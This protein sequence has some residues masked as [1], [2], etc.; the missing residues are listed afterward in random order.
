MTTQDFENAARTVSTVEIRSTRL[1]F[2][3][4]GFGVAAWAPL[5]PFVA[6]RAGLDAA[7]LG[8]LLLCL[9]IGSLAA[10]PVA[11]ALAGRWGAR[12]V[13]AA[14]VAAVCAALAALSASGSIPVLALAL[15]GLGAG[16][17]GLD[18]LMNIQAV[19]VERQAGR[20]MM[21]GFHGLY[22][23]GCIVGAAGVSALLGLG[24]TPPTATLCVAAGI[25]A[26]F[27]G[28]LPGLLSA[29]ARGGPA[30]AIPRG[31]VLGIGLL[32][33]VVFL[34]EGAALDW[35]AV[36]LA[37]ERG[38]ELSRAGLGYAAFS[39][40]M[41]VGR[42]AGDALVRR[43][44]RVRIV[45]FGALMAAAALGI[46]VLV[47]GWGAALL[48]YALVGAGCANIVPVLFTA[49]ARQGA[50][51]ERL[52]IPAV[53]TLGY[54]GVLTGPAAIGFVAHAT[55][56]DTAFLVIALMLLGVAACG[57]RIAFRTG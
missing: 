43:V 53:T 50:M 20:P 45:G 38:V 55:S 39:L 40:T 37:R 42:L 15:F 28:A 35:S 54:A 47:P 11:G 1:L 30:F 17:G 49:A 52:A 5:V 16:L 56:L 9:G 3:I 51:P 24:L 4:V 23:L 48:G 7:N 34:T 26:A 22:S 44:G 36:F 8:G 33:F 13:L 12:T 25:V 18:C 10:M 29:E 27:A 2:L 31:P 41:T 19:A 46:V 57:R 6:A 32:C 14:C 21:S